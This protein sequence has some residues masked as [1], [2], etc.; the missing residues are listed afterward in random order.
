MTS[1]HWHYDKWLEFLQENIAGWYTCIEVER[2]AG[3]NGIDKSNARMFF[4][5]Q[6]SREINP[7]KY[8]QFTRRIDA[9]Q[10]TQAVTVN[11]WC[12]KPYSWFRLQVRIYEIFKTNLHW[13]VSEEE[14]ASTRPP[15]RGKRNKIKH[16]GI[17][18]FL[19]RKLSLSSDVHNQDCPYI[20]SIKM[21]KSDKNEIVGFCYA[22]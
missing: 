17:F 2:T 8:E 12:A 5:W 1:P 6:N 7:W 18:R 15:E 9:V 4:F 22:S 10:S 13:E 14:K 21:K 20:H 11:S 19:T 3:N 16:H